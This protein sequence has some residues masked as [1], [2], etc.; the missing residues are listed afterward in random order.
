MQVG[1]LGMI[2]V[3]GMLYILMRGVVPRGFEVVIEKA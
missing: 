1:L 3:E 2:M